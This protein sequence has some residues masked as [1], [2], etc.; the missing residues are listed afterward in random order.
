MMKVTLK[1]AL[2]IHLAAIALVIVILTG[3]SRAQV[4]INVKSGVQLGWPTP[5]RTPD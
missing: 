4:Q 1:Q 2:P 3:V 5:N